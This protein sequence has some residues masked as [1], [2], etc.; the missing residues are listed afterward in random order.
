MRSVR[1]RVNILVSRESGLTLEEL[2]ADVITPLRSLVAIGLNEP[3][4]VYD[5][6]LRAEDIEAADEAQGPLLALPIQVD[7]ADGDEPEELKQV[8]GHPLPLAPALKDMESFISA[9]MDVARQCAVSLDAVEPRQRSGSLQGQVLEVV[10]AAETLHR[11]LHDEPTEFPFAERVRKA[12]EKDDSFN[13][14]ERRNVRDALKFTELTLEKR[15]LQ[16]VDELGPAVSTW[17]FNGQ[18][19]SWAF[20]AATI[21]N[22]LSHGYATAHRVHEDYGALIGVLRFTNAVIT[23][24]IMV[25]AGLGSGEELLQRLQGHP[26]LRHLVRQSIADWSALAAAIDP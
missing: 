8:A 25:Q 11:T 17:L 22:A 16:L 4:Q 20:T 6:R 14:R 23:L 10:N 13:S 1:E 9:W 7:P 19:A 15:L 12:L 18:A 26:R 5:I 21:R 24:R 3:V 2:H